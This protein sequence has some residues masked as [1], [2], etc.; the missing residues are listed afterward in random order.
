MSTTL[1]D[2]VI[3]R[4]QATG[5]KNAALAKIC[6]VQPPTSFNWASGKTKNIKGAPLL[7]AAAAFGVTPDWLASGKGPKF[8]PTQDR[9]NTSKA[10]QPTVDYHANPPASADT[11]QEIRSRPITL[12]AQRVSVRELVLQLRAYLQPEPPGVRTAVIAML[13]DIADRPEEV[14]FAATMADRIHG[15]LG[16]P[17]NAAQ[18]Q[19]TASP[20]GHR[21]HR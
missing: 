16:Y 10:D 15:M 8:P 2:R 11:P 3:E 20:R 6:G 12:P 7:K 19:S 13:K 1:K 9:P 5:L 21:G 17:G 18:P 4:M 14:E